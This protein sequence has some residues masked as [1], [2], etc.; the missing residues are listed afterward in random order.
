VVSEEAIAYQRAQPE[1]IRGSVFAGPWQLLYTRH[2]GTKALRILDLR[3]GTAA[4]RPALPGL[5]WDP[6][7]ER[8]LLARLGELKRANL[9]L[10]EAIAHADREVI[11][12]DPED[13]EQLRALGY[14]E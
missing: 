9:A 6:L 11:Q 8:S 3:A 1:R 5:R 12:I 4:A 7:L 13:R 2:R 14:I 10:G